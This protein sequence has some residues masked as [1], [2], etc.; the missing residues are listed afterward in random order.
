MPFLHPSRG[1]IVVPVHLALVL[2]VLFIIHLPHPFGLCL[3]GFYHCA[4]STVP[5]RLGH[6]IPPDRLSAILAPLCFEAHI[7]SHT[8]LQWVSAAVHRWCKPYIAWRNWIAKRTSVR[9]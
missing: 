6:P 2:F 8:Q 9:L 1:C 5:G 7:V 4:V 3:A